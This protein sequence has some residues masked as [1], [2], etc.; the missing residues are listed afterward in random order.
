MSS[1]K[2][3]R[4]WKKYHLRDLAFQSLDDEILTLPNL[5]QRN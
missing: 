2:V 3:F 4:Q 5:S 1:R